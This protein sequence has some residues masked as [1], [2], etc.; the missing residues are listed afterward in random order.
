MLDDDCTEDD[1]RALVDASRQRILS[2]YPGS[3]W[4]D[5]LQHLSSLT[6]ADLASRVQLPASMIDSRTAPPP[7]PQGTS[8]RFDFETG[9]RIDAEAYDEALNE[10]SFDAPSS[11]PLA[12]PPRTPLTKDMQTAPSAKAEILQKYL[13]AASYAHTYGPSIPIR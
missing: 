6:S 11:P 10:A 7:P 4:A 1:I 9:I 13:D 12:Y 3:T 2:D 8:Q 5:A